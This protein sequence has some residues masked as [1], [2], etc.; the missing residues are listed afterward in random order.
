MSFIKDI[1][2]DIKDIWLKIS[3]FQDNAR[4]ILH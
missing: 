4:Y 3:L 1:V 2:S